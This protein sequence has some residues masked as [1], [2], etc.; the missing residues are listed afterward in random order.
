MSSLIGSGIWMVALFWR[1]VEIGGGRPS[2]HSSPAPR[3]RDAATTLLGGALA[4]RIS[5]K[6]ILLVVEL[7]RAARV[8]VV[9]LMSPSG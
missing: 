6:R 2:S 3:D 5:Q 4:D 1:V 8:G 9:A 7:V